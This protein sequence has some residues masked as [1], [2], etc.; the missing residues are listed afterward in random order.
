MCE[1]SRGWLD[2]SQSQPANLYAQYASD[3]AVDA[4][5]GVI[6]SPGMTGGGAPSLANVSYLGDKNLGD[7]I[8]APFVT[9]SAL[10]LKVAHPV[11]GLPA[12]T[13]S[14]PVT[15]NA[16]YGNVLGKAQGGDCKGVTTYK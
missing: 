2:A 14:T 1:I 7:P 15:S 8:V 9:K 16:L 4:V 11:D 10:A 13:T 12:S 5:K 6:L 3:V